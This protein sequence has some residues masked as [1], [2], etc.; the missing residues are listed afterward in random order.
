MRALQARSSHR[1]PCLFSGCPGW[2]G[3]GA[4]DRSTSRREPSDKPWREARAR[5]ALP[6][7]RATRSLGIAR[8]QGASA[9]ENEIIEFCRASLAAYKVPRRVQFVEAVPTTSS[10]RIMRR[11][12]R[13]LDESWI[14]RRAH[15]RTASWTMHTRAIGVELN[16]EWEQRDSNPTSHEC[17]NDSLSRQRPATRSGTASQSSSCGPVSNRDTVRPAEPMIE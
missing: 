17:P 7:L 14:H 9:N 2:R 13:T 5:A 16:S 10:G 15:G 6:A 3:P 11:M 8:C 12:L 4:A 1:S